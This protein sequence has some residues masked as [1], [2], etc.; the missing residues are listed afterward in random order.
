LKSHIVPCAP[1]AL[2][3]FGLDGRRQLAVTAYGARSF[4]DFYFKNLAA[5]ARS[6]RFVAFCCRF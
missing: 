1:R 2:G 3:V 6:F 4:F 5:N